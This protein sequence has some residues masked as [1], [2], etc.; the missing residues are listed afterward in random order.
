MPAT[1][2]TIGTPASM[3]DRQPPQ[4]VAIDDEPFD[5]SVSET[6]RMT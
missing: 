5:S 2:S 1:G 6:M 4:T 3:S